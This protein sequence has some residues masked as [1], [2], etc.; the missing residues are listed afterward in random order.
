MRT[1]NIPRYNIFSSLAE[2]V[3]QNSTSIT[4]LSSLWTASGL[5]HPDPKVLLKSH[6]PFSIFLQFFFINSIGTS[7]TLTCFTISRSL[8]KSLSEYLKP[9]FVITYFFCLFLYGCGAGTYESSLH[10]LNLVNIP[11]RSLARLKI[12]V[13]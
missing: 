13:L 8:L 1:R 7:S 2:S 5:G 9:F 12:F 3:C 4:P 6:F 10:S 11:C